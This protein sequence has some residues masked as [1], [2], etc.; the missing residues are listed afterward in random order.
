VTHT[1]RNRAV[2]RIFHRGLSNMAFTV[3]TVYCRY[4]VWISRITFVKLCIIVT[5]WPFRNVIKSI[6]KIHPV[7]IRRWKIKTFYVGLFFRKFRYTKYVYGTPVRWLDGPLILNRQSPEIMLPEHTKAV[8]N[9]NFNL[10][11]IAFARCM[12]SWSVKP[13]PTVPRSL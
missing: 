10:C 7:F 13:F 2:N 11:M 9:L 1:L 8:Y 5:Y 6:F 4:V 12:L 3:Q